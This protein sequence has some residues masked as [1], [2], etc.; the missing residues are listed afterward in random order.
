MLN[1]CPEC[2]PKDLISQARAL[3]QVQTVDTTTTHT[4]RPSRSPNIAGPSS[5][6]VHWIFA[7]TGKVRIETRPADGGAQLVPDQEVALEAYFRGSDSALRQRCTSWA[8]CPPD[9]GV[10]WQKRR[11]GLECRQGLHAENERLYSEEG[12]ER[13]GISVIGR[14]AGSVCEGLLKQCCRDDICSCWCVE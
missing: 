8:V 12:L 1:S 9:S 4:R 3:F 13:N 7:T 14:G 2:A 11:P 6:E 10:P 5:V